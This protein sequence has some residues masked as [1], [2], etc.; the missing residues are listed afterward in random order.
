MTRPF[1]VVI[2]NTLVSKYFPN[3][4]ISRFNCQLIRIMLSEG[5]I[6]EELGNNLDVFK[7]R[8]NQTTNWS[9]KLGKLIF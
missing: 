7:I 9:E 1:C 4:L 6:H 3:S 2:E 8:S 5:Q